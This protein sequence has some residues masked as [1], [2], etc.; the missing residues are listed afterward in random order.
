LS[1]CWLSDRLQWKR[2]RKE[3]REV[4]AKFGAG[5]PAAPGAAALPRPAGRGG[6]AG[7]DD[8]ARADHRGLFAHG[9]DSRAEGAHGARQALKFK[10]GDEARFI[11]HAETTDR[12]LLFGTNGRFYTLMGANLPGGRGMGEPVRLMVDLPNEADIVR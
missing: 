10:D 12:I 9:L 7:G 4:R 3:L 2:I 6:A 1:T 5:A 11:F 8:R